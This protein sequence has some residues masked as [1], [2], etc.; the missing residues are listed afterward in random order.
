MF[1]ITSAFRAARAAAPM[2]LSAALVAPLAAQGDMM[3]R[4]WS[5]AEPKTAWVTSYGEC[6]NS[7]GGPNDLEPCVE[8]AVPEEFVVR[9]KFEFDKYRLENIVNT[10]ELARLEQYAENVKAT[11]A[12][13][14]LT[15]VGHTDAKGSF[16]YNDALGY[17]R[18]N[19][20]RDFLISRG[21]PE[22][23]IAPAESMGKRDLLPEYSPFALEQRRVV[24]R[25]ES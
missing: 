2:L 8:P 16:E 20:V 24:I 19:T 22:R 4:F 12:E 6:W 25:S 10:D 21:I 3:E 7:A 23:L 1:K 5:A 14:F 9:L 15:V 17:R 18:A 11:E 13:E